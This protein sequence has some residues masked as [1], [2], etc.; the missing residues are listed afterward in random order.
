MQAR[1]IMTTSVQTVGPD[2]LVTEIAK[3]LIE[4]NISAVPVVDENERVIGIVSEGDLMRRA[5]NQTE[6]RP[7][8]WL[9][10]LGMP[11]DRQ[12]EYI[13]SHGT[14][15]SDI[16]SPNVITV[17]EDAPLAEIAA[18][19]ERHRI[20]RV[21]VVRAGKLVGIVSRGDLLQGLAAAGTGVAAAASDREL[22]A[23][24][25][26][27]GEGAGVDMFFVSVVVAQGVATLWGMAETAEAKTAMRVAAESA[28][29]V[30]EVRDEVNIMPD[31]VRATLWA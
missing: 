10:W 29:G 5:E 25:E 8:W 17:G 27:A 1:D 2:T 6:R 3:R 31:M 22:K 18:T 11:D 20:K 12:R 13:K 24:I 7:S 28:A 19:L 14:H 4:R 16:M 26:K 9:A 21:P 15:A 23:A 30:K